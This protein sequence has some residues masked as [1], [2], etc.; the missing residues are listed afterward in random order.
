MGRDELLLALGKTGKKRLFAAKGLVEDALSCDSLSATK[1]LSAQVSIADEVTPRIK[2]S[3]GATGTT[4]VGYIEVAEVEQFAASRDDLCIL[5]QLRSIPALSDIASNDTLRRHRRPLP[6]PSSIAEIHHDAVPTDRAAHIVRRLNDKTN[7]RLIG[8]S[9]SGKT[10]TAAQVSSHLFA[11]N[12]SVSWLDLSDPGRDACDLVL[13]LLRTPLARAGRHLIVLDDA[14]SNPGEIKRLGR[15]VDQ[16]SAVTNCPLT[17]FVLGWESANMIVGEAFPDSLP[18]S[19][20]GDNVIP[21]LAHEMIVGISE[22]QLETVR[23]SSS[24]DLLIATLMLRHLKDVGQLPSNPEIAAAAY[25]HATDGAHFSEEEQALLFRLCSLSQLEIDIAF[26]Y[27]DSFGSAALRKLLANGC[28]RMNGEYL[29]VGHR[30]LARLMAFQIAA[31][32]PAIVSRLPGGGR[33]AVDYLRSASPRQIVATL[34]RLDIAGL[35][36]SP[37]DQ[38]GTTFLAKAWESLLIL[39]NYLA[40]QAKSDP[41]WGDNTASSAFAA[42][43]LAE[44]GHDAWNDIAQYLHSRWEIPSTHQLIAPMGQPTSD[45]VDFDEIRRSMTDLESLVDDYVGD[46]LAANIDFDRMH[47]T[48]ALGLLLGFEGTARTPR[49]DVMLRLKSIAEAIQNPD[50]SFYPRRVPWVSAR[51]LIGLAKAGDSVRTSETVKRGCDWLRRAYPEGPYRLGTWE[52]GTGT[53][54]TT[55]GTTSMCLNALIRCGV[56]N[57]DACVS[58]ATAYLVSKRDEWVRPGQEI[59]GAFAMETVL[60]TRGRWREI[61]NE[62]AA[63]LAWVRD[64]RAWTQATQLASESHDESCKVAQI[65]SSL[66]GIVWDTVKGELPL[67]LEGVATTIYEPP[68]GERG[69]ARIFKV[70]SDAI[71][72]LRSKIGDEI[73]ERQELGERIRSSGSDELTRQLNLWRERRKR[74]QSLEGDFARLTEQPVHVD[75]ADGVREMSQSLDALGSECLPASWTPVSEAAGVDK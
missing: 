41:T 37:S 44:I 23:R 43:A 51:V 70:L 57:T 2:I 31:S 75:I 20:F 39:I 9:A 58:A 18:V 63:L 11:N 6:T 71:S 34:E 54:N 24:G 68:R 19:C 49:S 1:V 36:Y 40:K 59:D 72:D 10:V 67:L 3:L 60:S 47:R 17:V 55:L 66:V 29:S 5:T 4:L 56:P 46:D 35:A 13:S 52:S 61:S 15:V 33:I 69:F 48:W 62:L 38:H 45:R 8:Q 65:A 16:I 53:W 21:K 7:V 25:G 73:M 22:E 50:G 14:Q 12:W 26:S 74:L 42:E 28:V 64:R 32:T 30:S 27:A